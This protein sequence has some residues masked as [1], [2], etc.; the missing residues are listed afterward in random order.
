MNPRRPRLAGRLWRRRRR[1]P[2]PA[3]APSEIG[4][5]FDEDDGGSAGVREPRRPKPLGP[6]AGAAEA[7]PADPPLAAE[8]P[9][10]RH[11]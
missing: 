2:V 3:A 1:E 7:V 9:D 8:L 5:W 4:R 10:P 6:M 11:A